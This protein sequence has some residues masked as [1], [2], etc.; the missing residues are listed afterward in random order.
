[1]VFYLHNIKQEFVPCCHL[2]AV[3]YF[4]HK[5]A[6]QCNNVVTARF[7]L[8]TVISFQTCYLYKMSS[9]K[10]CATMQKCQMKKNRVSPIQCCPKVLSHLSC[11]YFVS[12]QPN[13]RVIF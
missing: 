11:L 4:W 6:Y 12:K 7:L 1:M 13:F 2:D 3:L 9:Q 5:E 10:H 8:M